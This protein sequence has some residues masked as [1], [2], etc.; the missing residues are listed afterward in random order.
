M[1]KLMHESAGRGIE[2]DDRTLAHLRL[3][4]MNKLRR[5]EAFMFDIDMPDAGGHRILWI[6]ASMPLA[7]SFYGSRQPRIN[8]D[9]LEA[10]MAAANSPAGLTIVPEPP[11]RPD[12]IR[13]RGEDSFVAE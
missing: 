3:V 5:G 2:I 1:G 8:R 13:R 12:G 7:F 11:E 9:W 4:I 6:H 10:L